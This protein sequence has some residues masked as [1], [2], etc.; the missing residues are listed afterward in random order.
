[1]LDPAGES[2]C[3]ALGDAWRFRL[4]EAD[5]FV[6]RHILEVCLDEDLEVGTRWVDIRPIPS[7]EGWF[8]RVWNDYVED[9]VIR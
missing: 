8:E 7:G 1:M 6:D 5:A 4:N 2:P 3:D 9:R